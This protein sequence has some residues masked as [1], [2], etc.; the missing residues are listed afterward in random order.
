MENK[1]INTSMKEEKKIAEE[2]SEIKEKDLKTGENAA[3]ISADDDKKLLELK[4]SECKD[5]NKKLK[6]IEDKLLRSLADNENI[7]KR[8]EKELEETVKYS[9]KNFALSLLTVSDNFQ[10]AKQ[11]LPKEMPDDNLLKNLLIGMEAIEKD[12]YDA[13]LKNGIKN[14][15]SIDEKFNPEIHQAVSN[16]ESEK[17]EGNVVDELQQGFMIGERLLRPAMV[18]VSQGKKKVD[19][20]EKNNKEKELDE[21][22]LEKKS[23]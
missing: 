6:E 16:V 15:S 7:R 19:S 9:I 17:A 3:N 11:S 21:K 23:E 22:N 10:R 12:F 8:H 13:F 2:K 1:K 14:F 4:I 18:T 5:L 20:E